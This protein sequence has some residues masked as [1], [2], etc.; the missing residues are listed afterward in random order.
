MTLAETVAIAVRGLRH[1][2][3]LT[4]Q[5]LA[6]AANLNI[7]HINK[8]ENGAQNLTLET[9]EAIAHALDT[10]P[11]RLLDLSQE[12]IPISPKEAAAR[13]KIL[14]DFVWQNL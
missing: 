2:A 10:T 7:R 5:E 12:A 13:I 3:G 9:L 6:D 11:A 8:I 1:Q 14:A 4:Q